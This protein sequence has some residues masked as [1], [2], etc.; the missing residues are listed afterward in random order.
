MLSNV[1]GFNSLIRAFSLENS[2]TYKEICCTMWSLKYAED[3]FLFNFFGK[4]F[5]ISPTVS[6]NCLRRSLKQI[7]LV[8]VPLRLKKFSDFEKFEF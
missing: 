8:Y 3:F 6:S 7:S 1:S 2:K 5:F 4:Q